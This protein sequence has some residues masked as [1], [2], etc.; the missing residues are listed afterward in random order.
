MAKAT[1]KKISRKKPAA[2]K[3]RAT[4][5]HAR[6][7][8]PKKNARRTKGARQSAK[9]RRATSVHDG[10]QAGDRPADRDGRVIRNWKRFA[11]AGATT[12][13]QA[14]DDVVRPVNCAKPTPRSGNS[15][16]RGA[17]QL[18][19]G[20]TTIQPWTQHQPQPAGLCYG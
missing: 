2:P 1:K 9:G 8:E 19:R 3:S 15:S 12:A 7:A 14:S 5:N 16:G 17:R 18:S 6:N 4:A 13:A 20:C 11:D 10:V